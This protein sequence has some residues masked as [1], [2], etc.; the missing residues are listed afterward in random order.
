MN[1]VI[2]SLSIITVYLL[3]IFCLIGFVILFNKI[4]KSKNKSNQ[5]IDNNE[6]L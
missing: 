1:F 6:Q 5:L 2:M 3:F 4:I